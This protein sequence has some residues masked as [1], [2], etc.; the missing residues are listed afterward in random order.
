MTTVEFLLVPCLA[1]PALI[2]WAVLEATTPSP[3]Y[4]DAVSCRFRRKAAYEVVPPTAADA[5]GGGGDFASR[6]PA[7]PR[8]AQR[9]HSLDTINLAIALQESLEQQEREAGGAGA[10]PRRLSA[11]PRRALPASSRRPC[12]VAN[13]HAPP[14][15]PAVAGPAAEPAQRPPPE[16]LDGCDEL[17]EGL[18]GAA[19]EQTDGD[20][21]DECAA[22][23][24]SATG[25]SAS[26]GDE[27]RPH[28]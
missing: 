9:E 19:E 15:P 28:S 21:D 4:W 18:L 2:V 1:A 23:Q 13:T 17:N 12:I 6:V 22:P 16:E 5:T 14:P 10:T 25:A 26:D 20:D 11:S 8:T 3:V 7:V 27:A 24:R